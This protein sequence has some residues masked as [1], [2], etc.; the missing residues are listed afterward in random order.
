MSLKERN[1]TNLMFLTFLRDI[2]S[3]IHIHS[4]NK[5]LHVYIILSTLHS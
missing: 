3:H 5:R 2:F 1:A 4:I